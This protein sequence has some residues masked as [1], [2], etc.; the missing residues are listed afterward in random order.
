MKIYY[1]GIGSKDSGVHTLMEFINIMLMEFLIKKDWDK[2]L[3]DTPRHMHHQLNFKD[4][5]LPEDFV[6]FTLEDWLEYSGAE[7]IE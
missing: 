1:T 3:R 7:I 4:W 5:E 6:C 2:E